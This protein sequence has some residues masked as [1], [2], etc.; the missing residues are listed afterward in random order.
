MII[1]MICFIANSSELT[2]FFNSWIINSAVNAYI[3]SYK[4]NLR[5]FIEKSINEIKD[6]AEKKQMTI[7]IDSVILTNVFDNRFILNNICYIPDNENRIISM[8][9]F[10]REYKIKFQFTDSETFIIITIKDFNLTNQSVN[11]ILYTTI[12]QLQ[13]NIAAN[14]IVTHDIAKHQINEGSSDMN[15][16]SIISE[17]SE[18]SELIWS[19][20]KY[21]WI[22]SL[23]SS[24]T[25][26]PANLWHLR[27]RH[28][29][30]ITLRKLKQIKST[31]DSTKYIPYIQAKKTHKPFHKT[32]QKITQQLEWVHSDIYDQFPESQGNSIYNLTF[33]D[34][35]TQYTYIIPISDK[36]S[37]TVKNVFT[38]WI[39]K[40]EREIDYKIKCL[41]MNGGGEYQ[42]EFI[43]ILNTLEIQ[44]KTIPSRTSK[45]NDKAEKLNHTLNDII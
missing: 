24:L 1:T 7:G 28:A 30:T 12:P 44:H 18:A 16:T 41:R 19:F 6:F 11:D 40:V 35:V 21:L 43:S 42:D 37:E 29:S 36:S 22:S 13:A 25:Y 20:R 8:M 32:N 34:E 45:L 39:V 9:K 14:I 2:I 15:F 26:S 33:L 5:F 10:R 23:V 27:F 17:V 4:S 31:F 3:T 38:D